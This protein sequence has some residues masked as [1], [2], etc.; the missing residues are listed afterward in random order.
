MSKICFIDRNF[1]GASLEMITRANEIIATYQAGGYRLTLRQLYYQFVSKNWLA[2]TER[3]YKRLGSVLN[4]ARYAGLVDWS[5][6][7]D[8]NRQPHHTSEFTGLDSLANAALASYRLDRWAGQQYFVELWVEKAALAGVLQPLADS[9]HVTL[10]VNRGY[11]SA[12]AMFEAAQ[13]L[14]RRLGQRGLVLYL[15]DHDPSG[16]DMVRDVQE[17]LNTFGARAEVQKVALTM[18][19][20]EEYQPPPNPAKSTDSRFDAYQAEHGDQSWEVDALP[21]NVLEELINA[22]IRE[23]VNSVKMMQVINTEKQDKKKFA[24]ALDQATKG[25]STVD[26]R[27]LSVDSPPW[28]DQE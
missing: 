5:A 3:N 26:P 19:Q 9:W 17:R 8:R 6:I 24:K 2:N 25:D 4:D 20:V 28:E 16:E 10:M 1:Q 12:S 18:E 14:K 23:H 22:A 21:P 27:Y 13:R 15:G 7:E 11:S